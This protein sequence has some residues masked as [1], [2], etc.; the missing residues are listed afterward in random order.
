MY[1]IM[2]SIEL[3]QSSSISP[4]LLV[5]FHSDLIH[6]RCSFPAHIFADDLKVLI[7]AAVEKK[8]ELML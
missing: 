8:L 6:N 5:V 7:R 4:Y 2:V 3:A 1:H